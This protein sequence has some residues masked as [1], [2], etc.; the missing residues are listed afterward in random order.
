MHH[1]MA[2]G[3]MFKVTTRQWMHSLGLARLGSPVGPLVAHQTVIRQALRLTKKE[4][5]REP[6]LG[7]LTIIVQFPLAS[8]ITAVAVLAL[9]VND[10]KE[11][12]K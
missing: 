9:V 5:Q 4:N 10:K 6:L 11:I 7:R 2:L 8:I 1:P 12:C 3:L